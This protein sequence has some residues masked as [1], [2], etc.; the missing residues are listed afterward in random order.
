MNEASVVAQ[1]E[2][3]VAAPGMTFLHLA[4]SEWFA[5]GLVIG[6]WLCSCIKMIACTHLNFMYWSLCSRVVMNDVDTIQHATWGIT[7]DGVQEWSW[8]MGNSYD[9]MSGDDDDVMCRCTWWTRMVYIRMLCK[10]GLFQHTTWRITDHGVQEWSWVMGNSYDHMSGD[11][12]DDDAMCRCTWWMRMVY[13]CMLCKSGLSKADDDLVVH[14]VRQAAFL[15]EG[16]G[17][18]PLWARGPEIG[19]DGPFLGLAWQSCAQTQWLT[20][21]TYE[22]HSTYWPMFMND[23][24]T[25]HHTTWW[26][27]DHGVQEWSWVVWT[28]PQAFSMCTWTSHHHH[29][30]DQASSHGSHVIT[31]L[32]AIIW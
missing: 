12:D 4:G 22:K 6:S 11:D 16:E 3:E 5:V 23:V 25:I 29:S 28:L 10:S 14:E 9:H 18:K 19:H 15:V 31:A 30:C 20:S 1:G 2:G 21:Q 24:D 32:N 17:H 8:V 26:I 7:V 27:T 13:I